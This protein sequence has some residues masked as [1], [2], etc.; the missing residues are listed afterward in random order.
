M[1]FYNTIL[2]STH[3]ILTRAVDNDDAKMEV[4]KEDLEETEAIAAFPEKAGVFD[5][6]PLEDT[7]PPANKAHRQVSEPTIPQ[8]NW[9]KLV[10]D[11]AAV[12]EN[13]EAINKK[14]VLVLQFAKKVDLLL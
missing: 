11:V 10:I 4:D 6:V 5:K 2:H 13:Q 12:K 3:D 7:T 9:D 14:L 1:E 8:A